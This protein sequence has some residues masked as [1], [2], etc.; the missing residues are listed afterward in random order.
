MAP[1]E[2]GIRPPN[3]RLSHPSRR[4]LLAGIAVGTAAVTAG[5]VLTSPPASARTRTGPVTLDEFMDLSR[6]LTDNEF[7]LEDEPGALYLASLV[8][9]PAFD[10]PLRALVQATVRADRAPTTFSQVL[11]RGALASDAVARTAQQILVLWYSGLVNG[12]TADY[13][14]ALAWESLPFAVP[15]STKLGFPKWNE[16]P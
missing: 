12:R 6:I 7:S 5:G 8:N 11:R 14:E 13:L 1:R 9:A 16:A 15:P 4:D 10:T 2:S 3:D